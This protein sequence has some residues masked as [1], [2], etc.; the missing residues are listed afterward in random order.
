MLSS[1]HKLLFG[2]HRQRAVHVADWVEII[3]ATHVDVHKI[4]IGEAPASDY[5]LVF[6]SV[7]GQCENII[8]QRNIEEQLST[9][10]IKYTMAIANAKPPMNG[11]P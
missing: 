5:K 9:N 4:N 11:K 10:Q 3:P 8:A 6:N 2:N 1:R 7:I